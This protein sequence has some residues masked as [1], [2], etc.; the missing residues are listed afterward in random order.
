MR[1]ATK[2]ARGCG[3]SLRQINRELT[4]V[5]LSVDLPAWRKSLAQMVDQARAALGANGG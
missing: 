2:M 1:D 4:W 5:T 3:V